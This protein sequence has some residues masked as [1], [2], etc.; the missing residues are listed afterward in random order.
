MRGDWMLIERLLSAN[1][2]R[3]LG[4]EGFRIIAEW[5]FADSFLAA[6]TSSPL[7]KWF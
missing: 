1:V 2:T 3:F 7:P 5:R 6:N 4:F